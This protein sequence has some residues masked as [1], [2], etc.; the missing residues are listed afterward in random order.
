MLPLTKEQLKLHQNAKVC[1]ICGKG[2][3]K[4]LSKKINYTKVGDHCHYTGK[5]KSTAHIICN[6]K[7]SVPNEIPVF[8]I[9]V[10]IIFI[11]LSLKN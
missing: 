5:Y 10:R 7:L 3:L 2:I 6:L 4:K 8:F 1:H 9:M 11:T